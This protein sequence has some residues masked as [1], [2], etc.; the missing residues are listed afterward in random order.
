MENQ[1]QIHSI[2]VQQG[3]KLGFGVYSCAH[4][5]YKIHDVNVKHV[6]EIKEVD[7]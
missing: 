7:T 2:F 6:T 4:C 5:T 1:I 3:K